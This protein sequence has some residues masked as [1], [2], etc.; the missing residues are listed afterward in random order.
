MHT[1][2]R[3]AGG[4][5]GGS[6]LVPQKSRAPFFEKSDLGIRKGLTPKN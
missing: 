1:G 6:G 5:R 3:L 2:D 4:G